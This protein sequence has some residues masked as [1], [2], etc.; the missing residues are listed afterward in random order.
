MVCHLTLLDWTIHFGWVKAHAGI[1][2]NEMADT[3]AKEA[4]QDEDKQ[5]IIYNRIPTTSAATEQK[6]EGVIKWQ[7]QW[8]GTVKGALCR[9][10]FPMVEQR[11]KVKLP[12]TPELTAM[13][14]SHGKAKAY[15]H[16]FKLTESPMCPCNEG[17]Q[18]PEHLI[19][20]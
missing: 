8:E 2:G 16:R 12:I 10:F 19:Y 4:A 18:T 6:K 15:L 5:N 7:R 1:A 14:T 13:V 11:L 20:S 9:S 17:A 3:L